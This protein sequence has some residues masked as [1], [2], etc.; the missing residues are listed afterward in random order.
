MGAAIHSIK[1]YI[2]IK[3]TIDVGVVGCIFFSLSAL[4]IYRPT[5]LPWICNV[6]HVDFQITSVA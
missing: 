2:L 3:N 4:E 5:W 6:Q 1:C